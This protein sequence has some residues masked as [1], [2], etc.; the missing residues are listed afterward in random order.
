VATP[1]IYAAGLSMLAFMPIQRNIDIIFR[2]VHARLPT[3][4]SWEYIS[5]WPSGYGIVEL[6]EYLKRRSAEN[7]AGIDV[8]RLGYALVSSLDL[9]VPSSPLLTFHSL[10]PGI[11][12]KVLDKQKVGLRPAFVILDTTNEVAP[13]DLSHAFKVWSYSRPGGKSDLQVWEL[14]S[15]HPL[16]HNVSNANRRRTSDE[17]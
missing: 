11:F 7:A 14:R 1:W 8:F 10:N 12:E 9:Y 4:T 2:P 15:D 5:G 17:N 16:L 3:D 13:V 6:G